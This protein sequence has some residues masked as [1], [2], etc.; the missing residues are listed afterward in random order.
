MF[1]VPPE[2]KVVVFDLDDT[3]HRFSWS[4]ELDRRVYDII[5]H[6]HDSGV[7]VCLASMNSLARM[8]LWEYRVL[9]MFKHVEERDPEKPYP[10]DK[11]DMLKR[12]IRDTRE[13]SKSMLFFDDHI[14]HSASACKLGM[15]AICVGHDLVTW[16]A[17]KRGLDAFD[18]RKRRCSYQ[19][20]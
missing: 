4:R 2:L 14:G 20:L 1:P 13:E 3:L 16:R 9:H 5:R 19:G 8:F 12:I 17:V 15:K 6:F 11:V 7:V 10:K 18:P